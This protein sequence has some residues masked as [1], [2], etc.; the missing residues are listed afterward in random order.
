MH[1]T[2]YVIV[3]LFLQNSLI[4][5]GFTNPI[6]GEIVNTINYSVVLSDGSF[7]TTRYFNANHA[8]LKRAVSASN[9]AILKFSGVGIPAATPRS[10][11]ANQERPALQLEQPHLP[12]K[13]PEQAFIRLHATQSIIQRDNMP[14]PNITTSLQ[15]F[16]T[17]QA[18]CPME[19]TILKGVI[20]ELLNTS[21]KQIL[22]TCSCR[23][24][25]S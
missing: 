5:G 25:F 17:N 8:G 21:N 16:E 15:R 12:D 19:R 20:K 4:H 3:I 13:N 22:H 7:S 2:I 24:T 1:L 6:V 10:R 9:G 14:C 18:G 11:L 23:Q